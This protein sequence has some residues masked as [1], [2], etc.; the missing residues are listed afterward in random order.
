MTII[1]KPLSDFY[2]LVASR[3]GEV[4]STASRAFV[5]D[6]A[7]AYIAWQEGGTY[8]PGNCIDEPE[9]YGLL[10]QIYPAGLPAT[11]YSYGVTRDYDADVNVLVNPNFSINQRGRTNAIGSTLYGPDGW[12]FAMP[13]GVAGN[14]PTFDP[15]TGVVTTDNSLGRM[16]QFIERG[17]FGR[18]Y[19]GETMTVS[20]E[21]LVLIGGGTDGLKFSIMSP[22]G[23]SSLLD[24]TISA[25]DGVRAA[26]FVVPA[27]A[28]GNFLRF[29]LRNQAQRS[30]RNLALVRGSTPFTGGRRNKAEELQLCRRYYQGPYRI[31]GQGYAE[32]G[33]QIRG[34]TNFPLPVVMAKTPTL[35]YTEAFA[36]NWN[37]GATT[38]YKN[39]GIFLSLA[40]QSAGIGTITWGVDVTLDASE[41]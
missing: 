27:G 37:N 24:I 31:V 30:F 26:T 22:D 38:V 8:G 7:A 19:A 6:D 25:G 17:L 29:R 39:D 20:V 18:G 34:I 28:T 11:G 23:T 4:Y 5:A 10:A 2:Y 13:D 32:A 12:K 15:V 9:L 3:A 33:S 41:Y 36:T 35:G 16:E 1:D 21:D 14:A 40:R